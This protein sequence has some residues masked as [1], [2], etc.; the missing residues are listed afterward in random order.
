MKFILSRNKNKPAAGSRFLTAVLPVL[1]L[2]LLLAACGGET[3]PIRAN[4]ENASGDAALETAAATTEPTVPAT[5]PPDGN[6][7]DVTCKGSYT[8][9][10]GQLPNA[11]A[12]TV[13]EENLTVKQ[14]QVYYWM[15]VNA[16]LL[17]DNEAMPDLSRGLDTQLCEAADNALTWQQFFLQRALDSWHGQQALVLQGNDE[18]VP[19]EE[20]YQPNLANHEKYMTDMPATEV[21]YGYEEGF[22]P[23]ELHQAFLDGIPELL[24]QLASDQGYADAA[25]LAAA[26]AGEGTKEEA[27]VSYA[28]LYNRGY[29]YYTTL[30]YYTE[31]AEEDVLAHFT[32]NQNDYEA[33][34]ITRD[35]G[36]YVDMRHLL[37]VPEGAEIAADGTVTCTDE[38]WED[39]LKDA[40]KILKDW[41]KTLNP[42]E[43]SFAAIANRQSTD[44]GSRLHGGLYRNVHQG[45]LIEPLDKW[46]FD[47]ARLVGDTAVIQSDYGY[48]IVYF[49]ASREIYMAQAE[50]DT[51]ARMYRELIGAAKEKYPMTVNYSAIELSLAQPGATTVTPADVLY[52]DVAHERYCQVQLYLQQD[53]PTTRYGNYNIT[54]H[55]CGITTMAMVATYLSDTEL[56]PPMLCPIYDRYCYPSGTDGRLFTE[57]P[58]E[59][60]FYLQERVFDYRKARE[61]MEQ[62]GCLVV[63]VQH[64]GY[65]TRGGHYLVL[66]ELTEDGLVQVRDSNIFNYGRLMKHKEDAFPWSTITPSGM[67]YW[68]F[69][70]K[71]TRTPSCCRCGQEMG[72]ENATAM[73]T[74]DYYCEKC[75]EAMLRRDNY[76]LGMYAE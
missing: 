59:M 8:T 57:T 41:S 19:L 14:L 13:A 42:T 28:E 26:I 31:P 58:P 9:Q 11:V 17:G 74:E 56:T 45:Q 33:A 34:G 63:V 54:S 3:E 46:C 67:C 36:Y 76:I 10:D 71:I 22:Q 25:Q 47:E 44:V 62:D 20:A 61:A 38:A 51:T 30:T 37:M 50:A 21:L 27:L 43:W 15:E 40:E 23:N 7:D 55:G 52:P 6:P 53:Y 64:K 48:H 60:G 5:V 29:M 75:D 39:C 4:A 73:L 49:C 70:P 18:G 2:A 24:Q 35:S 12:A 16:W 65:W 69:E 72:E 66:E 32:Y 68:I 1:I